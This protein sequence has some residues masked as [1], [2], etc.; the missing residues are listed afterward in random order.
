MNIWLSSFCRMRPTHLSLVNYTSKNVCLCPKHQNFALKLK[1][2]TSVGGKLSTNPDTVAKL[3]I[4]EISSLVNE[5]PVDKV[6]FSALKKVDIGTPG[7]IK[8]RSK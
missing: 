7:V 1:A 3:S 5:L 4:E 8:K 2:I 6:V